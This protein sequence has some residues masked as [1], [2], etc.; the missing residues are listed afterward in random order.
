MNDVLPKP[1]TKE[2]LMIC[3]DKHLGHL[4]KDAQGLQGSSIVSMKGDESPSQSP[5][6]HNTSWNSHGPSP[7]ATH[8][9]HDSFATS[10]RHPQQ[11]GQI[12]AGYGHPGSAPHTPLSAGPPTSQRHGPMQPHRRHVSDVGTSDDHQ[13]QSKRHQMYPPQQNQMYQNR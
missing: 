8:M 7:I 9:S 12:D 2:G 3:L 1:F 10:L 6:T 5:A 4:K 11:Y 13:G